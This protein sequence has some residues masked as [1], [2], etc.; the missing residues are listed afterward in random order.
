MMIPVLKR[1]AGKYLEGSGGQKR[2]AVGEQINTKQQLFSIKGKGQWGNS[3]TLKEYAANP[4]VALRRKVKGTRGQAV[5]TIT[6]D[7]EEADAIVRQA[8][9][10]IYVGNVKDIDAMAKRYFHNYGQY[11]FRCEEKQQ[12]S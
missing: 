6:T 10:K 8:Y 4:L 2:K 12:F 1:A 7:P 5:G 3:K 9:G 11:I